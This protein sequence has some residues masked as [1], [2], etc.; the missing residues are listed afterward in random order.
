MNPTI[1][2]V[3][4]S[5]L[6]NL[7]A[8]RLRRH[9]VQELLAASGIAV[10]VALV[11]GV[12]V[13]NTS[14][15]GAAGQLAHQLI[16]TA[17]L[18]LS[19]RSPD[20]FDERLAQRAA[21]LPGVQNAS[22]VLRENVAVLG[23][24]GRASVQLVGV[25][26]SLTSLGAFS[27]RNF[28]PG[29]LSFGTGLA[30]PASI[31]AA[32]GAKL[33]RP[34][35]LLAG[36]NARPTM[37]GSLLDG[38]IV[39]TAATSPIAIALLPI[40][41]QLS[42]EPGRVTQLFIQPRAGADRRLA[43]ELALLAAGRLNVEPADHELRLLEGASK[44]NDQSTTL[45]AAIGGM[46]GF[47]LAL[48]AMLLTVPERRRFIADLR[49]QGFDARQVLLILGFQ[50][51]AL[52]LAASL[53]GI[54]LG[55][56]LSRTLFHRV[57]AYL[58][59]AFPIG[60]QQVIEVRT[61]LLALACGVAATLLA[62]L[63]PI[64]DLRSSRPADAVF[65][66]AG[67]SGES[68]S[69]STTLA[70]GAAGC[71]LIFCVS[72]LV[73]LVP[74]AT[75]LAGVLLALAVLC[76]VPVVFAL[77]ANLLAWASERI[78]GS[79]LVIAVTELRASAARSIALGGVAALAV[80]GS[81]AIGGARQDLVRGLDAN[82]TDFL[83]GAELWVTTGGNDLT[84]N[85]FHAAGAARAIAGTAGV[86]SVRAYKGGLLDVG[87]RRL[88]IIARPP[89][90]P[91]IIPSSQL[92]QGNLN[93]ASALVRA[94]GWAAVS[95][96]FASARHIGLGDAFTLPTPSGTERLRVAALTTNLGW[97][98]GAIILSSVDYS[99]GWQNTDPSAIEVNL[100]PGVSAAAARLAVARAL[101][102][103][104]GLR[105]QTL[106]E[107]EQQYAVDSRQGL[108]SLS[109]I[110]ALLLITAALA[111]ASA[112]GTAIWQRRA[113]LASLKIQGFD[114]RQLWR[115][116]LL[117]SIIVLGVGCMVGV[118]LGIYGHALASRWL[119]LT[120]GFPAPF[121]LAEL[122]VLSTFALVA[123]IA[124]AM[125]ALPGYIAAR[126]PAHLSMQD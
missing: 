109:Q 117:E 4:L 31:A 12:L 94:G 69:R 114:N 102:S 52:G 25:T 27:T 15:N 6:F 5:M 116:L 85:S 14:I 51:L 23:P 103:W 97:P 49:T 124:M 26:P 40:A 54:A 35:T 19:A 38:S 106:A 76:L 43:A 115:A 99:R 107:R 46:V 32:I 126:V 39:G 113:R 68:V 91:R 41:Q 70:I 119:K 13:A 16:G 118:V 93:R 96:A 108:R 79:M 11:F 84:T 81:V 21:L 50:A 86:A 78:H 3:R 24:R 34:L 74:S 29:G 33:G 58:A 63:P 57:P 47:L 42:G 88:W 95:A 62:S 37:F 8:W 125:I 71:L 9:A 112:L 92:L 120:T 7:Y 75:I 72:V 36:G 53:L 90:D 80:Y 110:A 30:L 83:S 77:L 111:V 10:G 56:V 22:A 64:F 28:G 44:P 20:G 2:G 45:F 48:N 104:P 61:I 67:G 121:A 101:G 100:K 65:R 18:E 82:F 122:Q 105:V 123:G 59:F 66:E 89:G 87:D 1:L 17:R 60:S 73:A 98:P 55:D